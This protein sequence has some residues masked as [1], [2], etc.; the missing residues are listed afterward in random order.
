MPTSKTISKGA[1]TGPTLETTHPL[2]QEDVS[3]IASKG[4]VTTELSGG[5]AA[6]ATLTGPTRAYT[7][8]KRVA[9]HFQSTAPGSY[10]FAESSD[11]GVTFPGNITQAVHAGINLTGVITPAVGTTHY[12]HKFTC[13]PS[14]GASK[15]DCTSQLIT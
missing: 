8:G 4:T 13:G 2:N 12:R 7:A 1:I 6:G 9:V 10:V 3:L 14:W 15:V 11:A 5:C